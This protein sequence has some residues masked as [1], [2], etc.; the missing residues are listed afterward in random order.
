MNGLGNMVNHFYQ[1]KIQP[2]IDKT[3]NTFE[4][5][6]AIPISVLVGLFGAFA[7]MIIFNSIYPIFNSDELDVLVISNAMIGLL[8]FSLIFTIMVSIAV[9]CI[10]SIIIAPPTKKQLIAIKNACID[11]AQIFRELRKNRNE[12]NEERL[13]A[14]FDNSIEKMMKH[15][16]IKS[17]Q[18]V[19]KTLTNAHNLIDEQKEEIINL[20]SKHMKLDLRIEFLEKEKKEQD[21]LINELL[22]EKTHTEIN[23]DNTKPI[24]KSNKVEFLD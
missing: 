20:K 16:D 10:F 13:T 11:Y 18:A 17:L 2:T 19:A 5:S 1:N 6:Q 3:R 9:V 15:Y 21:Q 14:L 7:L 22:Q 24:S 23:D 4:E 8:V 12:I